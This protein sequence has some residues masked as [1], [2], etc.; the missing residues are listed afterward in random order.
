MR[1]SGG[2]LWCTL[3]INY[4]YD[5]EMAKMSRRMDANAGAGLSIPLI[6]GR[7]WKH[8]VLVP[9]CP[10]SEEIVSGVPYGDGEGNQ[11]SALLGASSY[12][13]ERSMSG[14]YEVYP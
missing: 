5:I 14:D 11:P 13:I 9:V 7:I 12:S 2:A 3:G 6:E 10:N 4:N 8:L 1:G